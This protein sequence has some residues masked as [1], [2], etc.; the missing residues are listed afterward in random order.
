MKNS[1]ET[2]KPVHIEYV[3]ILRMILDW[4]WIVMLAVDW[5]FVNRVQFLVSMS[6]GLNLIIAKHT[7]SQ[8]AKN[9]AAGI[10][11][12]MELYAKGGFQ[13]GTVLIDNEFESLLH[14]VPIIA[15]NMT[16]AH[17]HIPMIKCRIRLMKEHGQG[18]LNT[19]PCKKIPQLMLIELIYHIVLWLNTFLMKS[20]VSK[21][22]LPQEMYILTNWILPRIAMIYLGATV[23]PTKSQS[24]QIIWT[25]AVSRLL[26]V[27]CRCGW[28]KK[29]RLLTLW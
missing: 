17:E 28:D 5:M 21:T 24:C 18:F 10:S 13:V 1:E 22:L 20:G 8:T 6:R 14:L 19:L 16:A 7:P 2:P 25:P 29:I 9:L 26:W 23:K 3:Q 11:C 27:W 12:I 4:H 15:I